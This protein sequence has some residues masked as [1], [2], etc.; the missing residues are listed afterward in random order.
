MSLFPT[1][2][3]F[4]KM[5]AAGVAV[6]AL[7]VAGDGT[8]FEANR[9]R[10]VSIEVRLPRLADSWD[11]FRIAMTTISPSYPCGTRLISSTD[12]SPT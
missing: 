5:G 11:G 4:L 2:R 9:P 1:R 6:G 3:K 8:I 10:L 12:C 7:T